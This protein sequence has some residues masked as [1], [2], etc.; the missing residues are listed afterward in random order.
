MCLLPQIV[1]SELEEVPQGTSGE[2]LI[3]GPCVMKG[4]L[5]NPKATEGTPPHNTLLSLSK[6]LNSHGC[7]IPNVLIHVVELFQ[8]KVSYDTIL[9][10]ATLHFV[11]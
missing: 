2:I 6:K 4:Y 3:K 10:L 1:D 5:N 11:A 8:S 7:C 9:V